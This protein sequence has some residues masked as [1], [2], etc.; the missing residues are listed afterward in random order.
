MPQ[1]A[2]GA[3]VCR[4]SQKVK[5]ER[6]CAGCRSER[7]VAYGRGHR[8]LTQGETAAQGTKTAAGDEQRAP[9]APVPRGP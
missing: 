6:A 3:A 2:N 8:G 9:G 1:H 4:E 5:A 7:T